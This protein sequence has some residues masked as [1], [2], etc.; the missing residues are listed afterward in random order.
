VDRFP[1]LRFTLIALLLIVLAH[2]LDR[3]A[4]VRLVDPDVY[5]QDWGRMLRVIGFLPLWG[6]MGVALLLHDFPDRHVGAARPWWC[7]GALIVLAPAATGL[8]AELLKITLRRERPSFSDGAYAFRS[9]TDRPFYSGGLGLPS[10]HVMVAFGAAALLARLFPRSAP[11]WYLLA[12]GCGLTRVL[13]QAHF[14]SDVVLAA[15]ASWAIVAAIWRRWGVRPS[16]A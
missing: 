7:R 1:W 11:V 12:A 4:Y 14:V 10:S 13:A 3:W 8:A 15:V 16:P 6:L 9:F 5:G 2:L